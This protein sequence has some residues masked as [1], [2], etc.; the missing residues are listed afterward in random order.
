MLV[1]AASGEPHDERAPIKTRSA[2]WIYW[3]TSTPEGAS[4]MTQRDAFSSPR[5]ESIT[6][7]SR[8]AVILFQTN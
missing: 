6:I 4:I 7:D 8:R 3:N 1:K 2:R 5:L